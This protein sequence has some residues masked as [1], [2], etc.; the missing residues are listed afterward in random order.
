MSEQQAP[1]SRYE[2]L[3]LVNHFGTLHGGHCE[4]GWADPLRP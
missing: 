3:A 1:S 2:L 4:L